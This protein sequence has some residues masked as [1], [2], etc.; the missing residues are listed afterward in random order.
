MSF[1]LK[2]M[3]YLLAALKHG[4]IAKAADELNI[5]ASALSSAIDQI[6]AHFQLELINR[7]HSRGVEPTTSGKTVL[8]KF[9]ALL[10]DFESILSE[11]ADLGQALTGSIWTP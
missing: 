1:I 5:A 4:N 3:R 6:E 2:A 11:G 8:L 7:K 10:E 9:N